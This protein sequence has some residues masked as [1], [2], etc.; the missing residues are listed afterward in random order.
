MIQNESPSINNEKN[1]TDNDTEQ[2][3]DLKV[4]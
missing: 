2:E 3:K 1:G 4:V